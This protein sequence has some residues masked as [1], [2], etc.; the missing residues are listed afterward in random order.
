ME[1]ILIK[2]Q[3]KEIRKEYWAGRGE[4]RL[5]VVKLRYDD[6]CGNG[7][8][9]FAITGHIY[10]SKR[11]N[12][13]DG[14]ERFADGKRCGWTAG[15]CLHE[16]IAAQC[17]ELAPF[18]KWHL[19]SSDGPMHYKANALYWAGHCGVWGSDTGEK[20]PANWQ[21]FA[22]TVVLGAVAGDPANTAPLL[23]DMTAEELGAW[24]DA[25]LPALLV[26]FADDMRALGFTY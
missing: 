26:A 20:Y 6:D 1:T 11:P 8:N 18:I 5:L 10:S 25:R 19:T 16:E 23:E 24:L 13:R 4:R 3:T 17:P 7:H 15:G 9:S 22:S 12:S 21:H 2:H 14:V